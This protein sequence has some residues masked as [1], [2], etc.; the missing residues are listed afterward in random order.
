[1]DGRGREGW[2]TLPL[3]LDAAL[4]LDDS[5]GSARR[6]ARGGGEEED[7]E[8]EEVVFNTAPAPAAAAA[9]AAA[10]STAVVPA[11]AVAAPLVPLCVPGRV[12]HLYRDGGVYRAAEM[13][14]QV[15]DTADALSSVR[16]Y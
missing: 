8:E 14:A 13:N 7:E 4:T 6:A 3:P 12:L 2:N 16:L 10:A 9:T 15:H 1:M 11:P 5:M